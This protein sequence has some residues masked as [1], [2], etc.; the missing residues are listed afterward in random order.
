MAMGHQFSYISL[1]YIVHDRVNRNCEK[2]Y[3]VN[4]I[5]FYS[6]HDNECAQKSFKRNCPSFD[7]VM[8]LLLNNVF[9]DKIFGCKHQ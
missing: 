2:V 9:I 7:L 5:D 1:V 6:I 8:P 3:Y 4:H